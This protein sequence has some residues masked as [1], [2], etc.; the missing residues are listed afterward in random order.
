MFPNTVTSS[1]VSENSTKEILESFVHQ[2]EIQKKVTTMFAIRGLQEYINQVT[3]FSMFQETL[4]AQIIE[5]HKALNPNCP[6]TQQMSPPKRRDFYD[7]Q[8]YMKRN[9]Q[10]LIEESFSQSPQK[11]SETRSA[12]VSSKTID[13]AST[14]KNLYDSKSLEALLSESMLREYTKKVSRSKHIS[15]EEFQAFE[16]ANHVKNRAG[17]WKCE[18][19]TQFARG[20][21][22]ECFYRVKHQK[23][24]I[25]SLGIKP[26]DII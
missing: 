18:H 20:F 21:C 17:P 12:N 14:G 24:K 9:L 8:D 2:L 7:E 5:L 16:S 4:R 23:V 1:K 6:N 13:E 26:M 15:K 11:N 19:Q 10:K 25:I 22:Q 3:Q